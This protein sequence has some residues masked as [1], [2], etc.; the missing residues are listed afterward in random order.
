[1]PGGGREGAPG[2]ADPHG[3]PRSCR[4]AAGESCPQPAG[5]TAPSPWLSLPHSHHCPQ[6][7]AP[8]LWPSLPPA[9]QPSLL[10][11][12][13][14]VGVHAPWGRAA[15][16]SPLSW[17]HDVFLFFSAPVSTCGT[18][19]AGAGVAW[20]SHFGHGGAAAWPLFGCRGRAAVSG[21][22]A[23]QASRL[24]GRMATL[25]TVAGWPCWAPSSPGWPG[26]GAAGLQ[27]HQTAWLGL[28][29]PFL[30]AV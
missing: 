29:G 8:S 4:R 21:T 12:H 19:A 7:L 24:H 13:R 27:G 14:L 16:G 26:R 9:P 23:P 30:L 10:P 15:V 20:R 18:M 17:E 1:M 5:I 11:A 6:P 2:A 25:D 28:W 3:R 22:V